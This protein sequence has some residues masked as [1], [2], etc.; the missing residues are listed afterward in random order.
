[1]SYLVQRKLIEIFVFLK[2]IRYT[3][4]I[5]KMYNNQNRKAEIIN[6]N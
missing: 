1:M 3:G 5:I 4:L 2:L 6:V